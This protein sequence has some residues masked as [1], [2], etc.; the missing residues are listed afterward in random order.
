MTRL[1][2]VFDGEIDELGFWRWLWSRVVKRR[3]VGGRRE[4]IKCKRAA[5]DFAKVG[6]S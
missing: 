4:V 3:K 2:D 1:I 6:I 5:G